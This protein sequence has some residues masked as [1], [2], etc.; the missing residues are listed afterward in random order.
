[1]FK[2]FYYRWLKKNFFQKILFQISFHDHL[3]KN[4]TSSLRVQFA[5]LNIHGAD[6]QS[7]LKSGASKTDLAMTQCCR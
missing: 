4:V 6:I 7:Q 2:I 3:I 5:C 1:M